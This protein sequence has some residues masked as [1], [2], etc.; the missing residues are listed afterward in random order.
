MR[1][2]FATTHKIDVGGNIFLVS[3]EN[4]QDILFLCDIHKYHKELAE[5]TLQKMILMPCQQLR[6]IKSYSPIKLSIGS[7]MRRIYA[8]KKKLPVFAPASDW[9]RKIRGAPSP[10]RKNN[11]LFQM[12]IKRKQLKTTADKD[13]QH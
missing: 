13:S 11:Q 12:K 7:T 10:A 4:D 2:T 8:R 3:M 9:A 5:K 6:M 1:Q